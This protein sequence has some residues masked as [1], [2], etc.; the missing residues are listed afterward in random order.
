MVLPGGP[1]Q[2]Y[3]VHQYPIV[4]R[5]WGP[6]GLP[7]FLIFGASRPLHNLMAVILTTP[8]RCTSFSPMHMVSLSHTETLVRGVIE[9]RCSQTIQPTHFC[10]FR[11]LATSNASPIHTA[12]DLTRLKNSY[13]LLG[14]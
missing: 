9:T 13:T 7:V 12:I 4:R 11:P 8:V 10:P 3:A 1:W 5:V 6:G 14:P 2:Y